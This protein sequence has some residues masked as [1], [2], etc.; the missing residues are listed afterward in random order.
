MDFFYADQLLN[1]GGYIVFHDTYMLAVR[2][3]IAFVLR[4]KNYAFASEFM[5]RLEPAWKRYLRFINDIRQSPLDVYAALFSRFRLTMGLS[6]L[7]ILKK[8]DTDTRDWK[9]HKTF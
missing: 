4:N 2:K 6:N 3:V 5:C 7:C 1:S 9:Y 8:I